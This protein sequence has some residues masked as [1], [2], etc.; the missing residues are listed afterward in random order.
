MNKIDYTRN[1]PSYRVS[2]E[3]HIFRENPIPSM[4]LLLPKKGTFYTDNLVIREGSATGRVL[5]R[6]VDYTPVI[7][8][9]THIANTAYDTHAGILLKQDIWRV[10]ITYQKTHMEDNQIPIEFLSRFNSKPLGILLLKYDD[11]KSGSRRSDIDVS[12]HKRHDATMQDLN[13]LI[14]HTA[15]ELFRKFD[16]I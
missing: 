8:Y 5:V 11:Y 15:E 9:E 16:R 10:Y 2:A 12:N 6:G 3:E 1:N 14:G 7:P 4:N 13:D